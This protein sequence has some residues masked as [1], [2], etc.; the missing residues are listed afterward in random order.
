VYLCFGGIKDILLFGRSS[1]FINRFQQTGKSFAKAKASNAILALMPRYVIELIAFSSVIIIVLVLMFTDQSNLS[2]IIPTL[3]IYAFAGF[4]LL[5]ALQQIYASTA[6]IKGNIVAFENIVHDLSLS[7]DPFH[8]NTDL[9]HMV[10]NKCFTFNHTLELRNIT[11]T[12]PG[13]SS[14]ALSSFNMVVPVNSVIGLVGPSGSGKSTVI[15]FIL[16]LISPD[17]GAG[18]LIVDNKPINEINK[19]SWQNIIGFVPQQIYLSEGSIAENIAF[20]IPSKNI[21]FDKVSNAIKLAQLDS[22]I[23]EQPSGVHTKVGERGVK[24]SGGQRQ[25]I[26][27]ARALYNDAEVLIFDEATS[28]LDGITEKL[29]MEAIQNFYGKKTIILIAHR[30]KTVQKCHNIFYIKNGRVV[31]QG[32]YEELLNTNLEFK[33]MANNA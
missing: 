33:K 32:S 10:D 18:Q 25:R 16:A 22:W 7:E 2:L 31:S 8:E 29:I 30:L 15:D 19:R 21:D 28:A 3:A 17:E 1:D 12:Y 11:F 13:K 26:G 9:N 6:Q 5:P 14:P 24:L 4:K 23:E 27:I 20:G